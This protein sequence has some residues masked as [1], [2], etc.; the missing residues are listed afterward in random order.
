MIEIDD[1]ILSI[2]LFE[3][4]FVCD[5]AN[6]FGECCI[7]GDS[8]APLTL[9]EVEEVKK[10]FQIVKK[11]LEPKYLQIIE[12]EGLFIIDEDGDHVTPCYKNNECVYTV[13]ENNIAKCAFEIAYEKG[14]IGFKKPISCHLYPIRITKYNKFEAINYEKRK[15]C[16][17]ARIKGTKLQ[18]PVYKFL[19]EPLTRLY[20]EEWY[21][22]VEI[23]AKMFNNSGY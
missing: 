4:H 16:K 10:S 1:K 12:N 9:E 18:V 14:E 22:K 7:E 13:F 15:I 21:K 11:Y 23:A 8:G 20:G 19:K 6:C 3:K 5:I 17:A 2:D